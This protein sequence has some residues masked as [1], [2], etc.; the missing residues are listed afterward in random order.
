MLSSALN[1]ECVAVSI[2]IFPWSNPVQVHILTSPHP[3]CNVWIC[4]WANIHRTRTTFFVIQISHSDEQQM[5]IPIWESELDEWWC[6]FI[7]CH[8]CKKLYLFSAERHPL[9]EHLRLCFNF[10][11]SWEPIINAYWAFCQEEKLCNS[12]FFN[13]QLCVMY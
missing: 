1:K 7:S 4:S 5:L 10:P 12:R 3:Y 6:L 13:T 9:S 2:K 11:K 8:M